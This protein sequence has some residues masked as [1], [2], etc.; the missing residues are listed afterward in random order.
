MDAPLIPLRVEAA[1]FIA[2]V[3]SMTGFGALV[4]TVVRRQGAQRLRQL[5]Y[6]TS[7]LAVLVGVVWL[8]QSW[9]L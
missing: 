8:G 4:G 5:M 2:A 6:G 9:P 3:L 7:S 1:Y